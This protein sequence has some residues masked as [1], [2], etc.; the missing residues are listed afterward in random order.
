M[1][2]L[3]GVPGGFGLGGRVGVP[4]VDVVGGAVRGG[5]RVRGGGGVGGGDVGGGDV[6]G[7]DVGSLPS[8]VMF[9]TGRNGVRA[10]KISVITASS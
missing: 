4:L 3:P 8:S 5:G 6:G 1:P 9:G 7:E 2:L 10:P